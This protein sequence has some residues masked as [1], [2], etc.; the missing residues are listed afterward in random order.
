MVEGLA[1]GPD[2]GGTLARQRVGTGWVGL[3]ISVWLGQRPVDLETRGVDMDSWME[4]QQ[5]RN[6]T[7]FS[8]GHSNDD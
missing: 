8:Q 3:G 2:A 5:S 7:D 1:G 4:I 6:L